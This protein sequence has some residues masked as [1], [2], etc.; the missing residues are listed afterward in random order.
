MISYIK[1]DASPGVPYAFEGSTNFKVLESLGEDLEEIVLDRIEQRIRLFEHLETLS[2]REMIDYGLMDFVRVF[3]KDEPHKISKLKQGRVRLIMSVSL[4]DKII[5]MVTSRAL[6]K[7]EIEHWWEIPSKPGIGFTPEM[8]KLV[9]NDVMKHENMCFADISG[10]DWS[11]KPWL[12]RTAAEGKIRLCE[13]PSEVWKKLVR[14][15]AIIETR[16]VYQFSDGVI[17][18]PQFEGIVNSGKYKTSR[19]NS[20]MRVFLATL[21]GSNHTIAA[22]DDT[23]ESFVEDAFD[24]Y[25]ALGWEL[26]DYQRVNDGF[27]F[28]SRWYE[29]GNAYF[30]NVDKMLMNLLHT[31]PK[32]WFEFDMYML[33]FASNLSKHPIYEEILELINRVGYDVVQEGAQ[34]EQTNSETTASEEASC[35]ESHHYHSGD[36]ITSRC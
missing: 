18:A 23:V 31:K 5:E 20:W 4:V 33:Q 27:E 6:H 22:G 29:E 16:S 15:E 3:V 19:D 10:W 32:D 36:T 21:V 34:N 13:N 9:Y 12:V 17:V 7:L 11:V 24:K 25:K 26:K 8:D 35:E 14:A 1:L 2:R 28:C 30:L